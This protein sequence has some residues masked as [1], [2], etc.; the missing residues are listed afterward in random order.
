MQLH[1]SHQR[2]TAS[3]LNETNLDQLFWLLKGPNRTYP[4]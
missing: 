3:N 4:K 1:I 2:L